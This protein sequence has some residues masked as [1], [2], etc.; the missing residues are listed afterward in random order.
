MYFTVLDGFTYQELKNQRDGL[1]SLLDACLSDT[2]LYRAKCSEDQLHSLNK[3]KKHLLNTGKNRRRTLRRQ[4]EKIDALLKKMEY[5]QPSAA[6]KETDSGGNADVLRD[7]PM[8]RNGKGM[9]CE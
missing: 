2:P 8:S 5:E 4:I 9:W 7:H 3:N 1:Q 6:A